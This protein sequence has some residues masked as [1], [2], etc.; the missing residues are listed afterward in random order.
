M[1]KIKIKQIDSNGQEA[2]SVMTTDGNGNN[3]WSLPSAASSVLG[4]AEDG[5]YTDSRYTGGKVPAV[6]LTPTTKVSSAIDSINEV[7]GLLL[8][9]APSALSTATL[10]LSTSTNALAVSGF[11]ANSL[12]GITA[13]NSVKRVTASTVNSNTIQDVGDGMDGIVS[14]WTQGSQ[15]SG[16]NLT[17]T[18]AT[19][20][21]KA[22]GVLRVSDNK[23]GGT[24]NGGGA[25][26]EGFFQTFDAQI[27]G[28]SAT[29]GQNSLQLRHTL[30]GNTNVLNFIRDDL[31][32]TP[33]VSSVTA[34]ENT[35][36]GVKSSGI[37]H[38]ASG[39][40][41]NVSANATNIAGQTYVS[42]TILGMTGPG[43]A[44]N[45]AAGQGGL[46]NPIA[47]N[48][49]N[50]SLT[51]QVFT[52]GGNNQSTTAKVT[53]TATN[54]NGSGNA[55]STGNLL[56]LSGSGGIADGTITGPAT[57]SRVYLTSGTGDTPSSLAYSA[58]ASTQ[59][60]SAAGY[61]H[62]AAI[63]GGVLRCDK[64][65]YSTGYL[66]A[67]NADYSVKD[68][69]QYVTYRFTLAAKSSISVA[70]TGTYTGLWV[71]LPG[72]SD[73]TGISPNAIGGTWWDAKQLYSGGGV[74][75]RTGDTLAGCANGT[76][77]S[78]TTGTSVITF[79]TQSSSNST[80]NAVFVRVKLAAGQSITAISIS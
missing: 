7:L 69:A 53:V 54:P 70:I 19:T 79:G 11:T 46:S 31:T 68:N 36:T 55:Q 39:S 1:S 47:L 29:V 51:N 9:N 30:S 63:V 73:N 38:Y 58:W 48:T 22:T 71:A 24:A 56:V 72:V 6:G 10:D 41:L 77:A 65:N 42:G 5:A 4:D 52:V 21:A 16:E 44:V 43:S 2:G 61:L 59:D 74:P 35:K 37:E 34:V 25:A 64:T 33:V 14:L 76:V 23:W 17:F 75:G 80:A 67:G 8:P 50:F 3:T 12:T 20:D 66:P 18:S 62:E 32:A 28:A 15:A 78:G 45:F 60:L 40:T 27:V 13:G 26:P 57:T 49:L